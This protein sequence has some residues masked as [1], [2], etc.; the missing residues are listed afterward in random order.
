MDY[1]LYYGKTTRT[2]SI[3][4]DNVLDTLQPAS[5]YTPITNLREETALL[6]ANPTSGPSLGER[7]R[8]AKPRSVAVI[9]NDLTRST[10][11]REMLPAVTAAL[12]EE[13]LGPEAVTVVI[14]TGTHRALTEDEMRQVTGEAVF[15]RYRVVNHYCDAEDLV[16]FGTLSTGNEVRINR[17]VAEADFRISIGEILFHY[18]AGFAGGRKSLIPGVAGYETVIAN[19]RMMTEPGA[20]VAATEGNPL[21]EELMEGHDRCPLH[22][23]VNCMADSNKQIIRI[24]TGDPG[25]AWEKGLPTFLEANAVRLDQRADVLFV[26]A[27]G[28]PKDIN[29]YQAHKALE[30]ASRAVKP[31]GTIVFAAELGEGYGHPVFTEWARRG[32]TAEETEAAFRAD[33]QFGAH[34]LYFLGRIA[35]QAD[36]LLLSQLDERETAAIFM[37]KAETPEEAMA[38]VADKHG[39]DYT[40]YVIPQ[41]GIVLPLVDDPASS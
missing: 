36:I 7:L 26:S 12:N 34:K 5:G 3:P 18:Y 4:Q 20:R 6:L 33:F 15:D 28:Y 9:V 19:H 14:A 39:D 1:S 40:A 23:I 30:L 16:S 8:A 41:G 37:R 2:L 25:E 10:P 38:F 21:H 31:G 17:T 24:V 11:T 22:F 32:M 29:M 35:R 13:G 27:G